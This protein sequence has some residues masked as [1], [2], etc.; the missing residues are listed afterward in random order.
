[1]AIAASVLAAI[2]APALGILIDLEHKASVEPSLLA[3]GYLFLSTLLDTAQARTLWL[4]HGFQ[5]LAAVFV[6]SVVVKAG[7]LF[8]EEM[9][10]L[11]L[12]SSSPRE[13][14]PESM[15][16]AVNRSMFW[17][18]N[19][20]LHRGYRTLL[21]V[22]DLLRIPAKFDTQVLLDKIEQHWQA[23]DRSGKHA[24]CFTTLR[25]FARQTLYAVPPRLALLAFTFSQPF[26]I[27]RVIT[28]VEGSTVPTGVS[29]EVAGGLIGATVLIYVGIA[30]C[31][32]LYKHLTYQLVTMVRGALVALIFKKTLRLD[33]ATPADGASITLMSTDI[34]GLERSVVFIHDIWASVLE[35]GVGIFLLYREIG[36]PCFLVVIPISGTCHSQSRILTALTS[37]SRYPCVKSSR[38]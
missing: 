3:G 6:V 12:H 24:L 17:W 19:V 29:L 15:S 1:M 27:N 31:T 22:P 2:V 11:P 18:L 7:L 28:H 13:T 14:S 4:R 32:C 5:P 21:S 23:A 36:T 34:D 16:G 9:P 37:I 10:E 20:L 30:V 25:A 38:H 33:A 8:L 35:L 26:L